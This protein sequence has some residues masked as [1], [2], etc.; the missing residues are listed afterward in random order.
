[1][2]P[3]APGVGGDLQLVVGDLQQA[4]GVLGV[5]GGDV[6]NHAAG[7]FQ[8][9]RRAGSNRS[10]HRSNRQGIIALLPDHGGYGHPYRLG[11]GYC[12]LLA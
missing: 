2:S 11:T 8:S 10:A 12:N 9:V 3:T 6:A 4:L 7:R 1:M 5:G